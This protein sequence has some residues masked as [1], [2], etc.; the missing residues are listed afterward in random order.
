MNTMLKRIFVFGFPGRYGGA[1]TEMHHQIL[2]WLGMGV[3]VHLI[4][5]W[6]PEGEELYLDMKDRGVVIHE[7]LEWSALRPED[8]ILGF[9]CQLFL[10]YLPDIRQYTLRTVFLNCMTWLFGEEKRAMR[11]GE[12][13]LFLFQNE[14][15]KR[16]L[17]P[18]LQKLNSGAATQFM[19]FHPYFHEVG[20]PFHEKRNREFFTCG[21]IS[22]MDEEKYAKETLAIYEAVRSLL[23]KKGIFLGYGKLV[24]EK[25]GSPPGWIRT[26]KSHYELPVAEFYREC[27]V[28]L[29]P[30]DLTENWPRVGF[31]A[32]AS[33]CVLIVDN[34]GGW[35]QMVEHGKTGWL[36][37]SAED[38]IK[39]ASLMAQEPEMRMEMA[40]AARE[41]GRLLAGEET[42]RKSWEAVFEEISSLNM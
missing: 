5:A 19:A 28:V 27:D 12:I 24:E 20:F 6:N 34:R 3:E 2:L 11:D 25:I 31:E 41:R 21:H 10:F 22:R 15:V 26:A 39:Y 1:P 7:P 18:Q 14:M 23:P 38:F 42:A 29:Q 40:G 16:D 36:C 33:G 37:D 9:C 8:S 32:M 13:A 17:Q 35:R 30:S 4:P